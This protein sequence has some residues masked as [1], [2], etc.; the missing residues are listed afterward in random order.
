MTVP[1][2]FA[3]REVV[4][5]LAPGRSP[6]TTRDVSPRVDPP[7]NGGPDDTGDGV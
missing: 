4:P 3:T 5:R 7:D 1:A 2:A 6:T